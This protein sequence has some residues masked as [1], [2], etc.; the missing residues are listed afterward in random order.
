MK[1]FRRVLTSCFGLG[2]LPIA[3]GTWGSL[4]PVV[5]FAGLSLLKTPPWC[6]TIAMTVLVILA[7]WGC[8][9]FASSA[10]SA[11]GKEDPGEVVLDEVA[12]QAITFMVIPALP[13]VGSVWIIAAAGFLSFRFFDILKLWPCKRLEKFPAGWGILLDDLMAG[14]YAAVVVQLII[15][16]WLIG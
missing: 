8:I 14:V 11:C 10:I 2:W 16:L 15:R 7:S 3:P 13:S 9:A 12:G 1:N 6:I 4:P 5:L